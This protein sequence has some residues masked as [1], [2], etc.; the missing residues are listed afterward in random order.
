MGW[1][2]AGAIRVDSRERSGNV[3]GLGYG[4]I[5]PAGK[6]LLVRRDPEPGRWRSV[7]HGRRTFGNL[8]QPLL[9]H[10]PE[11]GISGEAKKGKRIFFQHQAGLLT[12]I[13]KKTLE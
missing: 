10:Q 1:L 9:D 3:G 4:T 12:Q 13:A 2:R 6:R 7:S 5:C 11:D 8:L